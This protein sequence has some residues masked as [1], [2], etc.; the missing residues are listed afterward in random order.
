MTSDIPLIEAVLS[1][2]KE[3]TT[4]EFQRGEVAPY[5]NSIYINITRVNGI[6]TEGAVSCKDKLEYTKFD[7]SLAHTRALQVEVDKMLDTEGAFALK[8]AAYALDMFHFSDGKV[9][10]AFMGNKYL[11]SENSKSVLRKWANAQIV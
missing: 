5:E 3:Y 1:H 11:L 2:S 4:L 7:L 10:V 8:L 9:G 6:L